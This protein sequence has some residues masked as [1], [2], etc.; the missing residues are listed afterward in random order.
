MTDIATKSGDTAPLARYQL[1]DKDGQPANLTGATVVA[2]FAGAPVAGSPCEVDGDPVDG[3]VRLATRDHLPEV[4]DGRRQITVE[5]ETEVTY[6]NGTIQTF[7]TEGYDRLI[8]W[9]DLD[10][11]A[12]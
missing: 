8:V 12:G 1:I 10:G 7:P 5:F 3:I 6:L 11:K 9:T 2:R 4:P